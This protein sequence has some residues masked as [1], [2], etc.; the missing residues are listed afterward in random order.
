MTTPATPAEP[1]TLDLP[2]RRLAYRVDGPEDGP[3]LLLGSSVG[4]TSTMWEPQVAALARTHRVVRYDHRGHGRSRP[5][6]PPQS[7][8]DLG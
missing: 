4:S 5:T 3:V 2:G 7:I 6:T 1:V 8:A